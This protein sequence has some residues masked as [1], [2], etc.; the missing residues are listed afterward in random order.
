MLERLKLHTLYAIHMLLPLA[1]V[2]WHV[3]KL[4]RDTLNRLAELFR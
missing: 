4:D 2:T 3:E 1:I